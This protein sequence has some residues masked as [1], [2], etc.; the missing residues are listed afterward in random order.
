MAAHQL[1]FHLAWTTRDR[2]PFINASARGFV[3][4]FFRRVAVRRRVKIVAL[5]ILQTHVHLLIRTRP[6]VDLSSLVQELKGG[7][8][9]AANRLPG[10]VLG[11]RWA[12]EYSAT[13]VTPRQV[14]TVSRYIRSQEE[15][16]PGEG[17]VA[18]RESVER[19]M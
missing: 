10:N 1:Y 2:K 5:A 6:Q 17:V 3:D 12:S 9:H 15:R 16:H 19:P 11:L 4:G 7:S 14:E 13:T 18:N 8:S